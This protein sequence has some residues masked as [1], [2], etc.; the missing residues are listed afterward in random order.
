MKKPSFKH[1]WEKH[2]AEFPKVSEDDA[3]QLWRAILKYREQNSKAKGPRIQ[4]WPKV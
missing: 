2:E 1:F 3:R 4:T